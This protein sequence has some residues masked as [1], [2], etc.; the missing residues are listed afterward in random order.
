MIIGHG[1]LYFVGGLCYFQ[2]FNTV[3]LWSVKNVAAAILKGF[4]M[5]TFEDLV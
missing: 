5:E 2:V 1:F 4:T 3:G